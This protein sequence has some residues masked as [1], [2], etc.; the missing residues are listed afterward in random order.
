MAMNGE[1]AEAR[2]PVIFVDPEGKFAV[3][4]HNS[5]LKVDENM[6]SYEVRQLYVSILK[7]KQPVLKY[8]MSNNVLRVWVSGYSNTK[9]MS[10]LELRPNE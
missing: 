1:M 8:I 9:Q 6:M 2:R 5:R 7:N 10:C 4:I 3:P